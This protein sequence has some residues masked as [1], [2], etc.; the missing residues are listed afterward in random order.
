MNDDISRAKKGNLVLL[1]DV[2]SLLHQVPVKVNI[3]IIK[4]IGECIHFSTHTFFYVAAL[5]VKCTKCAKYIH[6]E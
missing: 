5:K 4:F 6:T 1:V 3:K 2:N